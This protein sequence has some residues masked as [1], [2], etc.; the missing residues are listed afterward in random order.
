MSSHIK[1]VWTPKPMTASGTITQAGG[2][3]GGFLCSSSTSGTLVI[4]AG[5]ASGGASILASTPMVAGQFY[6]M[7]FYVQD[8]AYATLTN[9]TGTFQI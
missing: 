3:I 8:G 1:E 2:E 6:P 7:K 5:I 9:C 4:T